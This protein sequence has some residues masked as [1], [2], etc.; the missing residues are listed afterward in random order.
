[1]G[2]SASSLSTAMGKGRRA[3]VVGSL[4]RK[5]RRA[6]RARVSACCIILLATALAATCRANEIE[7]MKLGMSF[8]QIRRIAASRGWAFTPLPSTNS[9][10]TTYVLMKDGPSISLCRDILSAINKS[11][12]SNLHEFSS[13]V[14][15]WSHSLGAP[16]TTAHQGHAE[17]VQYSSL[18]FRWKGGDN[19]RRSLSMVQYGT[20]QPE[21][22]YGFGYIS[23]PCQSR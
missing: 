8:D 13:L 20:Q 12:K 1:V 22:I 21:I 14:E 5:V 16:E 19:V 11:Y 10:S 7:G 3:V 2:T 17:G 15:K 9:G 18:G 4:T 23:H 6:A